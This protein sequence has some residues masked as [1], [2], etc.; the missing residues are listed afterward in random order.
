MLR[1]FDANQQQV[2]TLRTNAD[3]GFNRFWWGMEGKGIRSVGSRRG[4]RRGGADAGSIVDE[5]GGF[6]V[7][8]GTYKVV[9]SLGNNI[10]DSM[11]VVINDDPNAPKSKAV[12]DAL[13]AA[14]DR[15]DKSALKLVDLTDRLNEAEEIIKK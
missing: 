8:P 7:D 2:R 13:R 15:L 1:I 4:A 3:S 9:M 14:N 10:A 6:P 11:T 12:R 5:P